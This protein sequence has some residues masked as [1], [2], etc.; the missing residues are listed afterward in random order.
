MDT[1]GGGVAGES[2]RRWNW[3]GSASG[4]VPLPPETP[5]DGSSDRRWNW[6]GTASG[7]VDQPIQTPV[8][9][10][11]DRRWN[12]GGSASGEVEVPPAAPVNGASSRVWRWRGTAKATT[13]GSKPC[14]GLPPGWTIQKVYELLPGL[15]QGQLNFPNPYYARWTYICTDENNQFVCGSAWLDDCCNQ[16]QTRAQSPTQQQPYDQAI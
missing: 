5:V 4:E 8:D 6:S 10:A 16:A 13:G 14:D 12:W 11:S 3:S 15:N 7:D 2:T 9:G 1:P